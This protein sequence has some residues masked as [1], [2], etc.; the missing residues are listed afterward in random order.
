MHGA[1]LLNLLSKAIKREIHSP[2]DTTRHQSNVYNTSK[3]LSSIAALLR[4]I[5][6][7]ERDIFDDILFV[8][9]VSRV[10]VVIQ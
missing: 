1:R 5:N 3:C 2:K 4:G 10:R 7:A 6:V 9:S 8:E